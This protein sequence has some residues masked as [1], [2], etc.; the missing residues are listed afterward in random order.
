MA[1][2]PFTQQVQ[3]DT[4]LLR[5][6]L[7]ISGLV[8]VVLLIIGLSIFFFMRWRNRAIVTKTTSGRTIVSAVKVNPKPVFR[9]LAAHVDFNSTGVYIINRD[10]NKWKDC[11]LGLYSTEFKA[12]YLHYVSTIG[13]GDG[14][15]V[16]YENF[17]LGNER[18]QTNG[19]NKDQNQ[20]QG[21][22]LYC[23]NI[24]GREGWSYF[25]RS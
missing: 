15:V 3:P 22:A 13:I 10:R 23:E 11:N 19:L 1:A 14:I 4:T 2:L 18:L 5:R 6:F 24:R 16:P 7:I 17:K 25:R 20:P 21:L 8:F 9:Q 12:D